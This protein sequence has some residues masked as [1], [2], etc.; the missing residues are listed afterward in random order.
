[1][2]V[3]T[4][5]F[6][7]LKFAPSSALAGFLQLAENNSKTIPYR[8]GVKDDDFEDHFKGKVSTCFM[9]QL[10]T[11]RELIYIGEKLAVTRQMS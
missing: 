9:P 7:D 2:F 3:T 8:K 4:K 5:V 10:R 1:M 11:Q 6:H